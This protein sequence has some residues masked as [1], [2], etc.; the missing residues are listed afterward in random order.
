MLEE[1]LTHNFPGFEYDIETILN[2]IPSTL[3]NQVNYENILNKLID[4]ESTDLNTKNSVIFCI[5]KRLTTLKSDTIDKV[6][7]SI[8]I[9]NIINADVNCDIK[10]SI[11]NYEN[12]EFSRGG[13]NNSIYNKQFTY[14]IISE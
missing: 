4:L 10:E 5:L 13:L 11:I 2:L 6:L 7:N 14:D 12:S 8:S 3:S 9:K 1:V